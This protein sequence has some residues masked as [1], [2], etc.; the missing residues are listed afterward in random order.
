MVI[1]L[2]VCGCGSPVYSRLSG[3]YLLTSKSVSKQT[4]QHTKLRLYPHFYSMQRRGQLNSRY[5][6]QSFGHSEHSRTLVLIKQ[7]CSVSAVGSALNYIDPSRYQNNYWW[8]LPA[9]G[10]SATQNPAIQEIYLRR[11]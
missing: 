4:N 7:A 11:K 2:M 6:K 5:Y 8:I 10:I 3:T 1:Q 9:P